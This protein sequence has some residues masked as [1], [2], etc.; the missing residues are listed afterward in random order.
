MLERAL[1]RTTRG[2]LL[3]EKQAVQH[4]IADSWIQ[5]NQFRLQVLHAAWVVDQKGARGAR[6]E[7]AGVKVAMPTVLADISR[8]AMHLHGAL[9]VSNEMPFNRMVLTASILAVADGPTEM[10]KTTIARTLLKGAEPSATDWPSTHLPDRVAAA[11]Q[12]FADLLERDQA[13]Q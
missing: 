10:H 5:L 2:S 11:R 7:I 13:N 3:A 4:T 1:S 6:V 9:G 12:R 8:R